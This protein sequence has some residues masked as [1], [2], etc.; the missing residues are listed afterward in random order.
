MKEH[1]LKNNHEFQ[2]YFNS[3]V[4]PIVAEFGKRMEGWDEILAPGLPKELVIQSCR[5]ESR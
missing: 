4:Q 3:R 5:A 1:G 2:R